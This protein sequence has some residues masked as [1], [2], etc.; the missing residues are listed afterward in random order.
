MSAFIDRTGQRFGRLVVIR[1]GDDYVSP[2]G[3]R[4][5]QW[6]CRCE[7]GAEVLKQMTNL[8]SRSPSCRTCSFSDIDETGNTYGRLTV[9]G[10]A[11]RK[12]GTYW[13]CRCA[14]GNERVIRGAD[15]RT[16]AFRSCKQCVFRCEHPKCPGSGSHATNGATCPAAIERRRHRG[17]VWYHTTAMGQTVVARRTLRKAGRL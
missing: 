2:L 15:L 1:R 3:A 16:K 14:C 9:V 4:N 17:F 6:L 8:K 7:C 5:V 10:R 13:Y 12:N 11:G